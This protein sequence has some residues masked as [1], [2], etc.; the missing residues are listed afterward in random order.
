MK[1]EFRC[2]MHPARILAIILLLALSG[3]DLIDAAKAEDNPSKNEQTFNDPMY[4]AREYLNEGVKAFT[5]QEYDAAAQLFQKAIES[6]PDFPKDVPRMYLATAYMLQYVPGSTD[7]KS[8][9][10]GLK[11]IE[12][13]SDVVERSQD[14]GEPNVNAMLAIASLIYQLKDFEQAKEWCNRV[15]EIE[16]E[17]AE[18]RENKAEA[19][20]RIAVIIYD[21][22]LEQTGIQ[23]ENVEYL[24][25]DEKTKLQ[26]D[27]DEGLDQLE[28]A[29]EIRPDHFDAMIFQNLL[30]RE[31]AKMEEDED[32]KAALIGQANETY[33]KAIQIKLKAEAEEAAQR[34]KLNWGE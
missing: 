14:R 8:E 28:K 20:Y 2:A 22:V 13:F 3:Y 17:T 7:P 24:K 12:T 5:D 27:I 26:Q 32:I 31:A 33:T 4:E 18:V 19:H 9:Q 23:G 25:E 1:P 29:I 6:Y 34:K 11:A 21:T 30:W 16:E 10:M 15:I